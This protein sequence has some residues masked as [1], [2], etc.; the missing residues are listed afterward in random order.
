[1][2]YE[3]AWKL[4]ALSALGLQQQ[5]GARLKQ[6]DVALRNQLYGLALA[7][8]P[9]LACGHSLADGRAKSYCPQCGTRIGQK[10]L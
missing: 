7:I 6:S 9:C 5:Y 8:G 1:M 3:D 4:Q 2:T 10:S